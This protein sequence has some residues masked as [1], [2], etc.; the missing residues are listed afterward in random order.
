MHLAIKTGSTGVI[1]LQIILFGQDMS[2]YVYLQA[3]YG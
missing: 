3:N 2:G 1:M